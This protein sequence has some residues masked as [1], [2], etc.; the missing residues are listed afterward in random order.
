MIDFTPFK[1]TTNA[2]LRENLKN[3]LNIGAYLEFSTRQINILDN[4]H[5]SKLHNCILDFN[6]DKNHGKIIS[7]A[8]L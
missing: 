1:T 3:K 2:K 6:I 5:R 4:L 8:D 7:I